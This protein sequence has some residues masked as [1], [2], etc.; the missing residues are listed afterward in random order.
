MS[1]VFRWVVAS[2]LHLQTNFPTSLMKVLDLLHRRVLWRFVLLTIVLWMV[3]FELFSRSQVKSLARPNSCLHLLCN[4]W[5]QADLF[6]CVCSLNLY[7]LA[8][9]CACSFRKSYIQR[10]ANKSVPEKSINDDIIE[11][12]TCDPASHCPNNYLERFRLFVYNLLTYQDT[13]PP[14]HH[15]SGKVR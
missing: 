6:A 7:L 14:Y 2:P 4:P 10:L 12:S 9:I 3:H 8:D 13:T 5:L 1:S 11:V 15:L